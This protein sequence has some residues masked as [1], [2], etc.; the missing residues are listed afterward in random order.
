MCFVRA[1]HGS[2]PGPLCLARPTGLPNTVCADYLVERAAHVIECADYYYPVGRA[3]H[4]V[5][6]AVRLV[7][8]E[9]N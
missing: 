5:G 6:R 1:V 3:V 2:S 4:V 8:R 9:A 7:G